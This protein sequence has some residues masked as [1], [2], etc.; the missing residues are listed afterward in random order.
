MIRTLT[1]ETNQIEL[2]RKTLIM[3]I[4]NITPDSFSDG[5]TYNSVEA[6]VKRAFQ[7]VQEGAD[8]IDVGGESTRPDS[9][10]VSEQEELDRVIPVI[11][12]LTAAK[13][14]VPIS[15]DTY[16]AEVA[17]Q[18][19][20]A[21]ASIINDVW[22]FRRDPHIAKVAAR[23][24]CPVIL[25][26]NRQ[27]AIY[28]QFLPEVISDLQIS[29]SIARQAGVADHNIVLDP[30]IGFGKTYEHNLWLMNNLTP[31][32]KLGYPVLLATSRKSMIYRTLDLP[33]N[34]LIEGT[35]ATVT[36]GIMQGCDIVR[37]HDVKEIKRTVIMTDA[38]VRNQFNY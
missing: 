16:K 1:Y 20:Q 17:E 28:N 9:V 12:A 26:H 38:I 23:H 15:I 10:E 19:M 34:D 13:L 35:A 29:I 22:G 8:L 4:L 25:M 14:P 7:M 36:L 3:G 11:K 27:E 24:A 21:G 5:G 2:G 18:A 37:V 31:I 33:K 30:G 32:T 6:A